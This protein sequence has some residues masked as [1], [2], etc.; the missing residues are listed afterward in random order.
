MKNLACVVLACALVLTFSSPGF[1]NRD[2][3]ATGLIGAVLPDDSDL[4][5]PTLAGVD[6]E[7]SYDP[8]LLVGAAVGHDFGSYRFEGEIAFMQSDLDELDA[9]ISAFGISGTTDIDGDIEIWTFMFNGYYEFAG[10]SQMTPF[11]MAGLGLASAEFS[12]G[13]VDEQ[14]AVTAFQVGAG[15][16]YLISEFTAIEVKYRYLVTDDL[17][18]QDLDVDFAAH[19]VIVGFSKRF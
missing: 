12:I 13:N 17:E 8:G 4:S 18:L 14:D 5:S 3:Y 19:N 1:C 16:S 11:L 7:V 2:S 9:S 15:I 10:S 6:V